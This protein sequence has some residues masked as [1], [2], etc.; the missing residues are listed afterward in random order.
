MLVNFTTGPQASQ[1]T[2]LLRK[3]ASD[4]HAWADN[5]AMSLTPEQQ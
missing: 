3:N 4:G 1:A 5:V 2:I